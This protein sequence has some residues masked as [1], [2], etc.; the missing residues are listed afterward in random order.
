MD[1][2]FHDVHRASISGSWVHTNSRN[3]FATGVRIF[4]ASN[5]VGPL[6]LVP[7]S[8]RI[9]ERNGPLSYIVTSPENTSYVFTVSL[10]I[11]S[12]ILR[13]IQFWKL[14]TKWPPF[15]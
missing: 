4:R 2:N 1:L 7:G 10:I 11:H 5:D 8:T 9:L 13:K 14:K 12:E 3:V 15:G 6:F